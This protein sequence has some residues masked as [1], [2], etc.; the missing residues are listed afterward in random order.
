MK[1][2]TWFLTLALVV[3]QANAQ[4]CLC[5]LNDDDSSKCYPGSDDECVE[6]WVMDGGWVAMI[7]VVMMMFWALAVV[8]EEFFV[9]ALNIMCAE[10]KIPDDVAGATFMAAGASSPEVIPRIFVLLHTL[11]KRKS[12]KQAM[13]FAFD[14][15]YVSFCFPQLF[16]AAISLFITKSDLGL[17]V[18][19]GSEVFNQMVITAAAVL[20]V[21]GGVLKLSWRVV[22]RECFFYGL[23]CL[24]LLWV[25]INS[26]CGDPTL[27]EEPCRD[28]AD[29]PPGEEHIQVPYYESLILFC[30]YIV[31]AVVA[32]YFNSDIV[33]I[34]CPI[35]AGEDI[36]GSAGGDDDGYVQLE[37]A[38]HKG[39]SHAADRESQDPMSTRKSRLLSALLPDTG[40]AIDQQRRIGSHVSDV[41]HQGKTMGCYLYKKNRFYAQMQMSTLKWMLRWV[42]IDENDFTTCKDKETKE[43]VVHM[44]IYT[45]SRVEV[46][47]KEQHQ[48]KITTGSGDFFFRAQSAESMHE[49]IAMIQSLIDKYS[50]LSMQERTDLLQRAGASGYG[51]EVDEEHHEDL[52]AWPKHTDGATG[53]LAIL[54]HLIL[55]P[56]K[57][58][59]HF[60]VPDVHKHPTWYWTAI[61]SSI[62]WMA[63]LCYVMIWATDFLGGFFGI[64]SV[65]MGLTV[66]AVGTSFPNVFASMI[67]AKQGLGNMA[68]CAAFG[69]NLFNIFVGLGLPWFLY[70]VIYGPYASLAYQGVLVPAILLIV[71]LGGF[72]LYMF[73]GGWRLVVPY[74]YVA[75]LVYFV[76]LG[77]A[78]SGIYNKA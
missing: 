76:Y 19:V 23:A 55:L 31:Y 70:G 17:G 10:A 5:P 52:I 77:T 74:A 46:W 30:M 56:L 24:G 26:H 13:T 14:D 1:L 6:K 53:M 48:F 78:V 50:Q 72:V 34:I 28:Y 42:T 21:D 66:G 62:I 69:A 22:S 25:V 11:N 43:G 8:C 63:L 60:T 4:K 37:E 51:D 12:P 59:L 15:L 71:F 68:V 75:V 61:G 44:D 27:G 32:S 41:Q 73:I 29:A 9:P 67:V 38:G 65:V 20:Y 3:S 33:P 47:K 2:S 16:A 7:I 36:P 40:A 57:G 39:S 58:L 45:C 64:T 35:Q 18:V 49:C 54:M